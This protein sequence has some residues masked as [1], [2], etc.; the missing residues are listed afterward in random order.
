M[1]IKLIQ[2]ITTMSIYFLHKTSFFG[3]VKQ[4]FATIENDTFF[5]YDSIF[6]ILQY[7]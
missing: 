5:R 7:P 1:L 3:F 4:Y 6:A 2:K